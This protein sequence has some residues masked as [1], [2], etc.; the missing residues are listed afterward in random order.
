[1]SNTFDIANEIAF[2]RVLS[3]SALGEA[4]ACFKRG[5]KE[6]LRAAEKKAMDA[7]HSAGREY[8]K[9]AVEVP[10]DELVV[11]SDIRALRARIRENLL[12]CRRLG[13]RLT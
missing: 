3:G 4:E 13:N 11:H 5:D 1:M 9:L 2:L 7:F 8:R 10:D 12:A 6:G